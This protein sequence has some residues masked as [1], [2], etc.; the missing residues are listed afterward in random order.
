MAVVVV[1]STARRGWWAARTL[2]EKRLLLAMTALLALVIAWFGV[3]RPLADARAAAEQRLT[4]AVM[5][6]SAARAQAAAA[7]AQVAG[8]AG[9]PVPLPL[10]GFLLTSGREAGFTNLTVNAAGPSQTSISIPSAR[11]PAVFGW[12]AQLEARGVAVESLIARPNADQTI[13][14]EAVM[15][16]GAR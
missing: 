12:I 10:D 3:I 1:K 16:V 6:L 11:P 5:D 4:A 13:S 14:V 9:Q 7:S 8:P 15:R 2:R